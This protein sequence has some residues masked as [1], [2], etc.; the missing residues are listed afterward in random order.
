MNTKNLKPGDFFTYKNEQY[1]VCKTDNVF[2]TC[3]KINPNGYTFY[4][5]KSVEII[6]EYFTSNPDHKRNMFL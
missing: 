6:D 4:I 2:V 3:K 5:H 1:E